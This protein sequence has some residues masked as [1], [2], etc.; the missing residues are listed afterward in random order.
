MNFDLEAF[1]Q[2]E[3]N[4]MLQFNAAT[5]DD[6]CDEEEPPKY[7]ANLIINGQDDEMMQILTNFNCQQFSELFQQVEPFMLAHHLGGRKSKISVKTMFMITI[8]FCKHAMSFRLLQGQFGL[9]NS[10]LERIVVTTIA[11][12][13]GVLFSSHVRWHI[14]EENKRDHTLFENFP[15]SMCAIDASVQEIS[16]PK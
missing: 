14:H 10:Y 7:D 11:I 15:N 12:C 2:N 3:A 9:D 1:R 4:F 16:R 6:S 8:C 5:Q 13:H